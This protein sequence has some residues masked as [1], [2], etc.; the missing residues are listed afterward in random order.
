MIVMVRIPF[1]LVR[2]PSN[3]NIHP[4]AP[5]DLTHPKNPVVRPILI[6]GNSVIEYFSNFFYQ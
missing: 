3:Q 2:V 5:Y 4:L 1:V 6:T